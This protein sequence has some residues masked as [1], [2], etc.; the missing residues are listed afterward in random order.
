[1]QAALNTGL[2]PCFSDV[3]SSVT[4]VRQKTDLPTGAE[5]PPGHEH[6]QPAFLNNNIL[7]IHILK[8]THQKASIAVTQL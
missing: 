1:M 8:T 2:T 6:H 5:S 7:Y 4:I 3:L